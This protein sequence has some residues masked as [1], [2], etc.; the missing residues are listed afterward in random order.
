[1]MLWKLYGFEL[2]AENMDTG[3]VHQMVMT[4]VSFG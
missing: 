1:M 2:E 4:S 3:K